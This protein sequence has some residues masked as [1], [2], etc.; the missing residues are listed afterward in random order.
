MMIHEEQH[1]RIRFV[2]ALR[3]ELRKVRTTRGTQWLLGLT[4]TAWALVAVLISLLTLS[5]GEG[6]IDV[7]GTL[8][9]M[10]AF[11]GVLSPMFGILIMASDWQTRDVLT[12]FALEPRRGIVFAAKVTAAALVGLLMIVG[13]VLSGLIV[14]TALALILAQTL[15]WDL[16]GS[17]GAG[18]LWGALVG[19]FSGVS[20]G[21][22]LGRVT[23]P[24]FFCLL[25]GLLI[26]P[27]LAIE[28]SG[29]GSWLR[30]SAIS[31]A[32][33]GTGEW[34]P[35]LVAAVLWL[36]CPLAIGYWRNGRADVR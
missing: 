14:C 17:Y 32:G 22:A 6:G 33:G 23:L 26:D 12:L 25:Q 15:S 27:L 7:A 18:T 10:G 8:L 28:P 34:A 31:D 9:G 13:A 3:G 30:L 29:V 16:S 11:V 24:V 5:E 2:R 19:V 4:L 21:A 35:A 20:Y 1:T 36:A